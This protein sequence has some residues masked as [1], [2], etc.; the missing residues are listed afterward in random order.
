MKRTRMDCRTKRDSSSV[1]KQYHCCSHLV[2]WQDYFG[3]DAVL[4]FL[5]GANPA[6][7]E[8]RREGVPEYVANMLE[9][10]DMVIWRYG[11]LRE[12]VACVNRYARAED[13]QGYPDIDDSAAATHS[14]VTRV[15]EASV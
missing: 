9:N 3:T 8:R 14:L 7:I 1:P 2:R 5:L 11:D 15:E 13:L 12:R 4:E 6:M 10:V